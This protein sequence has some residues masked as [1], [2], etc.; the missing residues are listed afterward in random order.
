[1]T[2]KGVGLDFGTTNSAIAVAGADGTV[3][4]A[5]FAEA[6]RLAATFRSIL[7]FFHPQD[8][9]AGSRYA[10]SGPDAIS[11]YLSSEP[12]GRLIQSAKSFLAS[13]SFKQTALYKSLYTLE[14]LVGIIVAEL[15]SAA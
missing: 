11:A 13:R 9:G 8:P 1:M 4:L 7:Y 12:R 5:R 6:D 14:D 3:R 10:V 2:V 15:K